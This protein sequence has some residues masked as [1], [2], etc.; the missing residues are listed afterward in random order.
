MQRRLGSPERSGIVAARLGRRRSNERVWHSVISW[1][2][3]SPL[4]FNDGR[5][6]I[7]TRGC[8]VL[9]CRPLCRR[10]RRPIRL[11]IDVL[12]RYGSGATRLVGATYN[13]GDEW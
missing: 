6:E 11:A 3:Q 7:A 9:G 12:T 10:I 13:A 4:F 8:R 2:G 1:G 5:L